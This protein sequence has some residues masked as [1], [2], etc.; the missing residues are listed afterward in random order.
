V[1]SGKT[2]ST[3]NA[4]R[5]MLKILHTNDFHGALDDNRQSKLSEL[6]K[7]VDLYFDCGD[8]IKAGNL[9]IP[10]KPEP[11]WPRLAALRCTA[12]VTGNRES[13]PLESPFKA[14]IAGH[15]H[16]ILCANLKRKDT[17]EQVLPPTM[18]LEVNGLK[19]GIL[20][21]MVAMVTQKMATRVASQFLWDDPIQT[22]KRLAQELRPKV[23]VLI[24]LTHIGYKKD[25][26]LA[27][28]CPEIDIIFGG[29]SHTVL[30][31]AEMVGKTAI[32]QAGSHG[33]FAGLCTWSQ[34]GEIDSQL[35]PL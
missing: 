27:T 18:L 25:I 3:P 11:V 30:E 29:H 26:E 20:A 31:K 2:Y 28:Q 34:T 14:K 1:K 17:G 22:A 7:E 13:H 15:T 24:A 23:D 33:K 4:Q 32:C 6:R 16:P 35:R 21:V 8:C 10:L 5:P 19:V 9:S 12:S